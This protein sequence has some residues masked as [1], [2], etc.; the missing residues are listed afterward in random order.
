MSRKINIKKLNPNYEPESYYFNNP[1]L[2]LNL[3]KE[4]LK[5]DA[6]ILN[7]RLN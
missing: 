1:K 7:T 3:V 4:F 5:I 2:I 6:F